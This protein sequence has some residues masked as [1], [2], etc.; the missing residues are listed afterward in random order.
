MLPIQ[1][2]ID[3]GIAGRSDKIKIDTT[4]DG[5]G[6]NNIEFD[7]SGL[8]ETWSTPRIFRM[9]SSSGSLDHKD[10]RYVAVMGGGMG[11]G[12]KCVGSGIFIV[13]LE[14]GHLRII[15]SLDI[16]LEDYLDQLKM[17]DL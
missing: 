7:Y 16:K 4:C 1:F 11:S 3:Q 13:D 2:T 9:P 10:D 14:A 15:Q 6:I 5:Q 12:T 17:M 8:G